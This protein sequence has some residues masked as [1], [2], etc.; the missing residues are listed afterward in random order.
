MS[1]WLDLDE[2]QEYYPEYLSLSPTGEHTTAEH[3]TAEHT[4]TEHTA[5]EHMTAVDTAVTAWEESWVAGAPD[6]IEECCPAAEGPVAIVEDPDSSIDS[7]SSDTDCSSLLD[8]DLL[9]RAIAAES[10]AEG[11]ANAPMRSDDSSAESAAKAAPCGSL[12]DVDIEMILRALGL[13]IT[14]LPLILRDEPRQDDSIQAI[15]RA[16]AARS[17]AQGVADTSLPAEGHLAVP[18]ADMVPGSPPPLPKRQRAECGTSP[19]D[20]FINKRPRLQPCRQSQLPTCHSAR[21][22]SCSA[23]GKRRAIQLT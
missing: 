20:R 1:E 3:T 16:L 23:D 6:W 14:Q 9:E 12:P 22:T 11:I 13:D 19:S 8:I 17:A 7:S 21:L 10:A 15:L 5:A 4:A 18:T 2:E